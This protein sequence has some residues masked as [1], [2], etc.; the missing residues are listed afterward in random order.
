[1]RVPISPLC[2]WLS[3]VMKPMPL[4]YLISESISICSLLVSKKL[5]GSM[6]LRLI[7][8]AHSVRESQ[9]STLSKK[10]G[11]VRSD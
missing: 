4:N 11:V 9:R 5:H 8:Q 10:D 1:M 3:C 7:D 2:H 6:L